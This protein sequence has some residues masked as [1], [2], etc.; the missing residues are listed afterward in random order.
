[1]KIESISASLLL[2]FG[3]A[4]WATTPCLQVTA[5]EIIQKAVII[6]SKH[7]NNSNIVSLRAGSVKNKS[8]P[9]S[10]NKGKSPFGLPGLV[11]STLYSHLDF[12]PFVIFFAVLARVSDGTARKVA[13]GLGIFHTIHAI[14]T[15]YDGSGSWAQKVFGRKNMP[16]LDIVFMYVFDVAAA[17]AFFFLPNFIECT[18][19]T[20]MIFKVAG[21]SGIPF[22]P[23]CNLAK[24]KAPK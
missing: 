20:A 5:T 19:T 12:V 8:V 13:M 4:S 18:E 6:P 10:S 7:R 15:D 22:F 1:M 2:W 16:G 24:K 17:T 23:L 21:L 14:L 9:T 11:D 3:V